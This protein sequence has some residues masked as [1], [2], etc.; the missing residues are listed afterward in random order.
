MKKFIFASIPFS[1]LALAFF[2]HPIY[3]DIYLQSGGLNHGATNFYSLRNLA[4]G[5]PHF[6]NPDLYNLYDQGA[7]PM[8]LLETHKEKFN[9]SGI[10]LSNNRATSGDSMR[11]SQSAYSFPQIGLFQPGAFGAILYF[12]PESE[13]VQILKGDSVT[14]STKRFGIDLAAGPASGIFRI[15]FSAHARLGEMKYTG[16]FKR[17]IL[18]APALRFDVGSR[19][20]PAMEIGAFIGLGGHFDSLESNISRLERVADL[21]LPRYGLLADIDGTEK[22]PLKGNVVFELGKS[23]LFGEYK[24]ENGIG[25]EYPII[26]TDY[27]TFQT[28]WLYSFLVKDFTLKPAIRFAHRSE[29][30]QGYE[31][32]KGNQ[33]PFKKGAEIADLKLTRSI[34]DYGIGG[35]FSFREMVNLL[36]EWESANHSYTKDS[37]ME[38]T[39]HRFTVGLENHLDQIPRVHFPEGVALALRL[40]WTWSEEGKIDPGFRSTQFSPYISSVQIPTR[41]NPLVAKP[42]ESAGYGAFHLG[43][44]LDVL[45]KTLGFNGLLSFPGQ[46]ENFGSG[47]TKGQGRPANG[48]EYGLRIDYRFF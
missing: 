9:A 10:I 14:V 44:G 15:G 36:I 3:A 32:I 2:S 33:D 20:H 38:E 23:R 35:N 42:D 48:L 21:T 30:A 8:G 45:K 22:I 18:E 47:P 34:M 25:R 24:P 1:L 43:I 40:G 4:L 5:E 26:W 7:S 12:Q 31:G 11:I 16:A 29:D 39:Y 27:S 19:I 37:A 46:I 28:Q 13:E 6:S 17:V 41:L